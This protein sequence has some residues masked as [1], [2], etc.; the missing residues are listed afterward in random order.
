MFDIEEFFY[1][2]LEVPSLR[3]VSSRVLM[4]DDNQ[5]MRSLGRSQIE[6][7]EGGGRDE[8]NR[9]GRGQEFDRSVSIR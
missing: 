8:W 1:T 4:A 2:S 7:I 9:G 5:T 6:K 3:I